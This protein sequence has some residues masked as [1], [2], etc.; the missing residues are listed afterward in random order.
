MASPYPCFD[1]GGGDDSLVRK[2]GTRNGVRE[3]CSARG[4][5]DESLQMR[6]R[7]SCLTK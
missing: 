1:A 3:E 7:V 6:N 4:G 5:V 2:G